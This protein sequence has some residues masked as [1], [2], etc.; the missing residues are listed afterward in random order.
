MRRWGIMPTPRPYKLLCVAL[1]ALTIGVSVYRMAQ[2]AWLASVTGDENIHITAGWVKWQQNRFSMGAYQPPLGQLLLTM[3]GPWQPKV[4]I[5]IGD[6]SYRDN[7]WEKFSDVFMYQAGNPTHKLL[8]SARLHAL[9]ITVLFLLGFTVF[10]LRRFDWVP[11]LLGSVWLWLN[12]MILAHGAAARMDMIAMAFYALAVILILR[13]FH[14]PS[15]RNLLLLAFGFAL[16]QLTKSHAWAL[17]P[18]LALFSWRSPWRPRVPRRMLWGA[19]IGVWLLLTWLVYGFE[20][21]PLLDDVPARAD[22]IAFIEHKLGAVPGL[23][24][25]ILQFATDVPIPAKSYW[26]TFPNTLLRTAAHQATS[27]IHDWRDLRFWEFYPVLFVIKNTLT[28]LLLLGFGCL[29]LLL[30]W[31]ATDPWQRGFFIAYALLLLLIMANGTHSGL[32]HLLP[33]YPALA[34]IVAW[35]FQR[36]LILAPRPAIQ[37]CLLILVLGASLLEL[38]PVGWDTLAFFNV[39]AGGPRLGFVHSDRLDYPYSLSASDAN[40]EWG[41]HLGDL[42]QTLSQLKVPSIYIRAQTAYDYRQELALRHI[43][44]A[45]EP[46]VAAPFSGAPRYLYLAGGEWLKLPWCARHTPVASVG[47][48]G[49]IYK[50]GQGLE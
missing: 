25:A 4:T 39:V 50:V 8:R 23:E 17:W 24:Q 29:G 12:P 22:K 37:F 3:P 13:Y 7:A 15:H 46:N 47:F 31:R 10:L 20:F 45:V 32:Q 5:P 40:Y 11:A 16:A 18:V 33:L 35:G 48:N 42:Q 49:R 36:W 44:A 28:G 1:L 41:Q 21:K 27:D 38:A 30:A 6:E 9:L 34:L 19:V 2:N 14:K 26:L 43:D